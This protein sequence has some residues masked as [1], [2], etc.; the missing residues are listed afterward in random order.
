MKMHYVMLKRYGEFVPAIKWEG[1]VYSIADYIGETVG[2]V[3]LV[4]FDEEDK[5]YGILVDGEY[6]DKVWMPLGQWPWLKVREY[7]S[8]NPGA[9]FWFVTSYSEK[10]G[11]V[12]IRK[13][14]WFYEPEEEKDS[15]Q[16]RNEQ[17]T[18]TASSMPPNGSAG[19]LGVTP[20][21]PEADV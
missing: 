18:C 10:R 6:G 11:R 19:S 20:N 8:A 16:N 17:G 4:F 7:V 9:T 15:V 3:R 14:A 1:N 12:K 2:K 21:T 13:V 5:K